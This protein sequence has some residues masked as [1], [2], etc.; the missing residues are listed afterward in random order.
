[1]VNGIVDAFHFVRDKVV[2]MYDETVKTLTII[3]KKIV[4]GAKNTLH[5]LEEMGKK[6][7]RGDFEGAINEIGEAV[8]SI[9]YT[10]KDIA[11]TIYENVYTVIDKLGIIALA[12]K[13]WDAV[14][15]VPIETWIEVAMILLT[16][17]MTIATIC[18]LGAA[19]IF[20]L[21]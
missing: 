19:G 12:Y 2:M 7:I 9:G 5:H 15:A 21:N 17:V 6:L 10:I 11:V 8:I 16:V 20:L 13:F 1:M 14:Q 18:S 4:E 3:G